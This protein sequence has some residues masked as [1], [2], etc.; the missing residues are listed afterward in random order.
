MIISSLVEKLRALIMKR[1][2]DRPVKRVE[3]CR[4]E[5]Y[6]A[7]LPQEFDGLRVLHLSDLHA[8]DYGKDSSR[9]AP[10]CERLKP[11]IVVFTG[12]LFSR[13]DG[14]R[15]LDDRAALL[16]RLA[17]TAPV[18]YV[19][20]N[21]EGDAPAKTE[22]FC[23]KLSAAGINVLR[24]R[25]VKLRRGGAQ[26]NICGLELPQECYVMPEGGY[27]HLRRLTADDIYERL[28]RAAEQGFTLL[29]AH[30]PLPFEQYAEWGADVTLS[31]HIHGGVVRIFGVGLLSPE[32][33][34][35]PKYTK[36]LYSLPSAAAGGRSYMEVSAGL[37]KFRINNPESVTLCTLRTRRQTK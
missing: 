25:T 33:K 21:H 37:G 35:F 12:D 18:Y 1:V 5:I 27:R 11:D 9:L 32:R 36:G 3:I 4:E 14:G 20:G 22:I 13:N 26:I 30:S 16:M 6:C 24:D 31:G 10:L 17:R 2:V 15:Q 29:L 7:R 34:F 28:G 19:I 8:K 23:R